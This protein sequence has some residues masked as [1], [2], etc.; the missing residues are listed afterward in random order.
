[1]TLY[2]S[3]IK[4]IGIGRE[5]YN[6]NFMRNV[7]SKPDLKFFEKFCHHIGIE[8]SNK[9]FD[10]AEKLITSKIDKGADIFQE[11]IYDPFMTLIEINGS[12]NDYYLDLA[13][14]ANNKKFHVIE[15]NCFKDVYKELDKI[16]DKYNPTSFEVY[17]GKRLPYRLYE[18]KDCK[19]DLADI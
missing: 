9:L 16:F 2:E 15:L 11:I 8:P 1:M 14:F 4:N 13:N 10:E 12:K 5:A 7:Y 19:I 3:L 6:M 17:E 18:W